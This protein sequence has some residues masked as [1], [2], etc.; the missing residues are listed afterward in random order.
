MY[1]NR[2][3]FVVKFPLTRRF[4]LGLIFTISAVV[5]IARGFSVR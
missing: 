5:G 4:M 3:A 2:R 1:T